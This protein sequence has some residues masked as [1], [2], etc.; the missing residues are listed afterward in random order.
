MLIEGGKNIN[1]LDLVLKMIKDTKMY[2]MP[3]PLPNMK[4]M[5]V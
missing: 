2:F 1:Y 5:A 3:F 4:S